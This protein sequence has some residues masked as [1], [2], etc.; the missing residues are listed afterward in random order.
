MRIVDEK[1]IGMRNRES[2]LAMNAP[3]FRALGHRLVDHIAHFLDSLPERKVAPGETPTEVR[4]ALQADRSLPGKG[5]DAGTVLERT[6]PIVHRIF[7]IL[8]ATQIALGRQDR[9]IA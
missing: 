5:E 2:A 4:N 7:Q 6:E 9:R 3:E 8:L 1:D